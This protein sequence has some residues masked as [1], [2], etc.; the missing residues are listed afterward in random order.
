MEEVLLGF[1]YTFLIV[2]SFETI[3]SKILN[4]VSKYPGKKIIVL[5]IQCLVISLF[6]FYN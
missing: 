1:I 5:A 6:F 3:F 4:N 2:I